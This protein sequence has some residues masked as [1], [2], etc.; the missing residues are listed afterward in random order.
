MTH[1]RW[2]ELMNDHSQKLTEKE[3][4]EGWYFDY[5]EDYEGVLICKKTI[6]QN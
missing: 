2:T 1:E 3:V 6:K 4:A 5:N